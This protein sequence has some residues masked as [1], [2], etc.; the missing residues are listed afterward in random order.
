MQRPVTTTIIESPRR[1]YNPILKRV[2][3]GLLGRS[4]YVPHCV[5]PACNW[6]D[7]EHLRTDHIRKLFGGLN[8]LVTRGK[9]QPGGWFMARYELDASK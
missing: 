3:F 9:R 2:A 7:F 6:S 4:V 8:W 5:C 1:Y